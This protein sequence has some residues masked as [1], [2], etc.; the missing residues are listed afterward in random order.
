M[1]H[2]IVPNNSYFGA[3][4]HNLLNSFLKQKLQNLIGKTPTLY[5]F[6]LLDF[7]WTAQLDIK[8]NDPYYSNKYS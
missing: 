8:L 3:V 1:T 7:P 2:P 6:G 4:I 5:V